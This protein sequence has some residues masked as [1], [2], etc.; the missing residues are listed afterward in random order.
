MLLGSAL[1]EYKQ[2]TFLVQFMGVLALKFSCNFSLFFVAFF[3]KDRLE[4]VKKIL[5]SKFGFRAKRFKRVS[6]EAKQ[7]VRELLVPDPDKRKDAQSALQSPWL[8]LRAPT[9]GDDT[10]DD[11]IRAEQEELARLSMIKYST[12]PKLKKMVRTKSKFCRHKHHFDLTIC[13]VS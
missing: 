4:V 3:G 9:T 1:R 8:K 6:P 12:H 5:N 2:Y 10:K 13:F 7:F 11:A